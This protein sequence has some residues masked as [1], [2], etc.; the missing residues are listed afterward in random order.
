MIQIKVVTKNNRGFLK[1]LFTYPFKDIKFVF[2]Q[3]EIYEIPSGVKSIA[4][5]LLRSSVLLKNLGW[6]Q[7][8][9]ESIS[10]SN[11]DLGFSYNR[12]VKSNKPYVIILENPSALIN[13]RWDV[14]KTKLGKRKL[15]TCFEDKNLK[16]IV[17]ISKACMKG[18]YKTYEVPNNLIVKQIYPLICDNDSINESRI[19]DRANQKK[20]KCLY[21]SSD[22][23]LK[24]GGEILEAFN[25]FI[26][27]D[28][29]LTIV[30]RIS[31]VKRE[32]IERIRNNH[33]IKLIEFNLNQEQLQ[34]LYSSS[35][36]LLMPT[37]R[38]SFNL[39]VLEAMKSGCAII[40]TPVYAIKEMAID[41]SNAFLVEQKY[42]YWNDDDTPN[43]NI[44]KNQKKTID[45]DYID[46][47]LSKLIYKYI[48]MLYDN[49]NKLTSMCLESY[50]RA[51]NSEFSERDVVEKWK[52]LIGDII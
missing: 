48:L 19:I 36:I 12:F 27:Q 40:A 6:F 31:T 25:N 1:N 22:F 50:K 33:K 30:T 26:D 43:M 2:S 18:L 8:L 39:V 37:R 3:N 49:R 47:N 52:L 20:L 10:E 32:D 45:A 38:D 16:A 13:Y 51:N 11:I 34:T 42:H 41:E 21:I 23:Y 44:I 46:S 28:I 15:R 14:A 9:K 5:K 29:E 35:A 17:C 24:G 4:A 7:V